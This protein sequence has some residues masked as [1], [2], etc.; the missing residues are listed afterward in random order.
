M[1]EPQTPSGEGDLTVA[2][3]GAHT[4]HMQTQD[5]E[6]CRKEPA[7]L[8]GGTETLHTLLYVF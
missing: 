5:S 8:S 7:G 4:L 2:G 1:P 3:S 6:L